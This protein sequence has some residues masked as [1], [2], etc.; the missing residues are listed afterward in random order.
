VSLAGDATNGT[1][2]RYA[3]QV[4]K[5]ITHGEA[6]FG[7]SHGDLLCA[8]RTMQLIKLSVWDDENNRVSSCGLSKFLSFLSDHMSASKWMSLVIINIIYCGW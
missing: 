4:Q 8:P 7:L 3:T 1:L 6:R 2:I 5:M